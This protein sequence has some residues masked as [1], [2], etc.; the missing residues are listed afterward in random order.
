MWITLR[1]IQGLEDQWL[2]TSGRALLLAQH[3]EKCC[4]F[5]AGSIQL[6][7]DNASDH[8]FES[9][10][11][12]IQKL[13]LSGA[14]NRI[15]RSLLGIPEHT[16]LLECARDA[17]NYIAHEISLFCIR[18]GPTD[19]LKMMPQLTKKVGDLALADSLVSWWAHL[20]EEKEDAISYEDFQF[21]PL[22]L[23]KWV[24][25][26]LEQI[27][28][29]TSWRLTVEQCRLLCK[30]QRSQSETLN[31]Q[32]TGQMTGCECIRESH[33]HVHDTRCGSLLCLQFHSTASESKRRTELDS[34]CVLLCEQ[35]HKHAHD[36]SS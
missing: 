33:T 34:D 32:L 26:P 2:Q 19:I 20:I 30:I 29:D 35:C 23:T 12:R 8:D 5:V 14:I 18:N 15:H 24:L 22:E 7:E 28:H 16:E 36:P 27:D 13:L 17:R 10:F 11:S 25:G 6:V 21:Y 4:I 31:W 9:S 3:F 1:E